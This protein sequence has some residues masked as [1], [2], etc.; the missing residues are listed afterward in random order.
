MN[1]PQNSLGSLLFIQPIFYAVPQKRSFVQRDVKTSFYFVSDLSK[2]T[3]YSN[4][5]T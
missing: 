5:P 2:K 4:P 3:G 1:P